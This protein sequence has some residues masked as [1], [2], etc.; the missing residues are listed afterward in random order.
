MGAPRMAVVCAYLQVAVRD[1]YRWP[2]CTGRSLSALIPRLLLVALPG[3][4]LRRLV[5]V[6]PI[7]DAPPFQIRKDS[8]TGCL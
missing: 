5:V 2:H 8:S 6:L 4:L 3:G 7:D 1:P